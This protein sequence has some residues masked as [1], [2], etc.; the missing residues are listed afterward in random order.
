MREFEEV[1]ASSTGS[2]LK[3]GFMFRFCLMILSIDVCVLEGGY[4]KC[5]G[6]AEVK[7]S[8]EV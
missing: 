8:W 3:V 1:V 5:Y 7:R 6:C 2:S 4:S